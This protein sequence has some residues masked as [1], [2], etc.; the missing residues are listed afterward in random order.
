MPESVRP[1][2]PSQIVRFLDDL[3]IFTQDKA[4]CFSQTLVENP[5]KAVYTNGEVEFLGYV[6]TPTNV[7]PAVRGGVHAEL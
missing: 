1:E 5:K 2:E 6:I 4:I 3:V 7:V